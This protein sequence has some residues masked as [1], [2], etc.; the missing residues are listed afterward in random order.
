MFKNSIIE[1]LF[2]KYLTR[3]NININDDYTSLINVYLFK[4]ELKKSNKLKIISDELKNISEY[5]IHSENECMIVP[6]YCFYKNP[7][8]ND[9]IAFP[10]HEISKVYISIGFHLITKFYMERSSHKKI[11]KVQEIILHA[12]HPNSDFKTGY[13]CSEEKYNYDEESVIDL[14]NNLLSRFHFNIDGCYFKPSK[15]HGLL[16]DY[17]NKIYSILKTTNN[18]YNGCQKNGS[19]KIPSYDDISN[20]KSSNIVINKI[21]E[22]IVS[23]I[24]DCKFIECRYSERIIIPDKIIHESGEKEKIKNIHKKYIINGYLIYKKY[25]SKSEKY[26]IRNVFIKCNHPNS[27][28]N[29]FIFDGTVLVSE[30]AN[31]GLGHF[32]DTPYDIERLENLMSTIDYRKERSPAFI[33][34][35]NEIKL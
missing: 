11:E 2:K 12:Y 21:D 23:E 5:D 25:D 32:Y 17:S 1:K 9:P 7:K 4:K 16:K 35:D 10:I 31:Y 29:F 18:F 19:F 3:F 6:S 24:E 20:I 33:I 22:K 30:S 26:I 8:T 15:E 14:A 13:F 28:Y 27:T 34:P